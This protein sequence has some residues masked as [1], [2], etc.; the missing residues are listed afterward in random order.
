MDLWGLTV[1]VEDTPSSPTLQQKNDRMKN[2][3]CPKKGNVKPCKEQH[4]YGGW[5]QGIQSISHL[6]KEFSELTTP[7]SRILFQEPAS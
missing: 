4:K 7:Q 3:E 1:T 5:L 2:A 6:H